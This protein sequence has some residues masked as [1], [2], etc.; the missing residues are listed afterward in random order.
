[1]RPDGNEF[2]YLWSQLGMHVP[3]SPKGITGHT[4]YPFA[5]KL[6][7]CSAAPIVSAGSTIITGGG[8]R[9]YRKSICRIFRC[10]APV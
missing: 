1:M 2:Y 3:M 10:L 8:S 7:A 4:G 9:A 5:F 6:V